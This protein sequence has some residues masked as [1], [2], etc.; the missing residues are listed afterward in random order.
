MD[1]D[2]G[3][4]TPTRVAHAHKAAAVDERHGG[5]LLSSFRKSYTDLILSPTPMVAV[6]GTG[7]VLS[8]PSQKQAVQLHNAGSSPPRA[9][10]PLDAERCASGNDAVVGHTTRELQIDY[11]M[12][13]GLCAIQ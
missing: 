7:P 8:T 6:V 11:T 4:Q 1:D 10:E 13:F 3:G 9:S 2:T 12:R 5:D